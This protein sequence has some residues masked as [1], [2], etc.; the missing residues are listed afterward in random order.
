MPRRAPKAKPTNPRDP[1]KRHYDGAQ[2]W[3]EL[4]NEREDRRYIWVNMNAVDQGVSFYEGLGYE[5]ERTRSD[6]KHA[7]PVR[8][9]TKGQGSHVE[10]RGHVLM[11]CDR[12]EYERVVREG[13]DGQS[14]QQM[15]DEI[16]EQTLKRGGP[17][18]LRGI[19]KPFMRLV[20]EGSTGVELD[21]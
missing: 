4:A 6:G 13:F 9:A 10:M 20:N 18:E 21:A 7:K 17:D 1:K 5:V 14:G 8:G 2:L 11:S 19:H 15:F 3:N 12:K 16:E